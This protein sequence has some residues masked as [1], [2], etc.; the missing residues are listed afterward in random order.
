MAESAKPMYCVFYQPIGSKEAACLP[1]LTWSYSAPYL[2]ASNG[3]LLS[4]DPSKRL[5]QQLPP[6]SLA[7]AP[8]PSPLAPLS[9]PFP[10]RHGVTLSL[11]LS[12]PP[13]YRARS[14]SFT[15]EWPQSP[16]DANTC[17][18]LPPSCHVV[19]G[20]EAS[21]RCLIPKMLPLTLNFSFATRQNNLD[22]L[23]RKGPFYRD[24]LKGR[25]QVVR[26]LQAC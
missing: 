2:I 15:L 23:L 19:E 16:H 1:I 9:H 6:P 26:M 25:S 22:A 10:I 21:E 8:L 4:L 5:K 18:V 24:P 7:F 17:C 11:C 3:L 13:A 14:S 12:R 20:G